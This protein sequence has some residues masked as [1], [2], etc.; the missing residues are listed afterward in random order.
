MITYV[1]NNKWTDFVPILLPEVTE[2]EIYTYYVTM[3]E[4]YTNKKTK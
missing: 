1:N 4:L 3:W 2:N